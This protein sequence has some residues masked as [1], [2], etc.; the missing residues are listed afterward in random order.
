M[1][2]CG[3]DNTDNHIAK[4]FPIVY[5]NSFCVQ[6]RLDDLNEVM[7]SGQ[8]IPLFDQFHSIIMWSIV[9]LQKHD[10]CNNQYSKKYM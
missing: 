9:N 1:I 8:D 7:F 10:K 6:C 5:S 2:L 4:T 3:E